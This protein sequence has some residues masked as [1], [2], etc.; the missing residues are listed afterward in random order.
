MAMSFIRLF[1]LLGYIFLNSC[2]PGGSGDSNLKTK[3]GTDSTINQADST[4]IVH[5]WDNGKLRLIQTFDVSKGYKKGWHV[6]YNQDQNPI[7]SSLYVLDKLRGQ[8][9]YYS[10]GQLK[11]RVEY[12]LEFEQG[13][14][15]K[16]VRNRW[17][18]YNS[19]G[20]LD[21][22]NSSFYK[23]IESAESPSV[24][25]DSFKLNIYVLSPENDSLTVYYSAANDTMLGR[26]YSLSLLNRPKGINLK[27]ATPFDTNYS[28]FI[29]VIHA[30]RKILAE[31]GKTLY[32]NHKMKVELDSI[33]R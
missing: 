29:A 10:N 32:Q 19:D 3:H 15:L 17:K 7:D 6:T 30:H 33:T 9:G 14:G 28:K 21:S 26:T 24:I 31:D 22:L 23:I 2:N 4:I 8:N 16:A 13:S 27:L 18:S 25:N 12:R 5:H 1:C 11:Y 20:S